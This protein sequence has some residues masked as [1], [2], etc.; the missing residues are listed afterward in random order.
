M[1]EIRASLIEYNIHSLK[2]SF[3]NKSKEKF[4]KRYASNEPLILYALRATFE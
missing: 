3:I 1:K 2:A 4:K